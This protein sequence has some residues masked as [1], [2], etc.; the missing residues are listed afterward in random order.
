MNS[1]YFLK[2]VYL[3]A[4]MMAGSF[5]VAAQDND[6][7]IQQRI[8]QQEYVFVPQSCSSP[9]FNT[10]ITSTIFKLQVTT[11]SIIAIFPY[12]GQSNTPQF[13]RSDDN[14]IQ[15]SSTDFEYTAVP[16]KKGKWEITIKPKDAKGIRLFLT[17]YN[18]GEAQMD[19][20]SP[21]RESMLYKGY[22]W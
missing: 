13:G 19:V 5:V 10:P 16:K 15:F 21:R 2:A 14:L 20:T 1:N 11:D 18:N 3:F 6:S 7:L 9:S 22:V 4:F 12:F 8:R 17:V